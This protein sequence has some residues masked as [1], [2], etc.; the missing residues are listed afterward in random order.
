M[1]YLFEGEVGKNLLDLLV[2]EARELL[3]FDD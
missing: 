1:S 3:E 2:R